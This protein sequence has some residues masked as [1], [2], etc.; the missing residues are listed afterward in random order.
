M[1]ERPLT[2]RGGA[3]FPSRDLIIFVT[4]GV[5]FVTLVLQGFTLAPLL[6][7]LGFVAFEAEASEER[8]VRVAMADAALESL[9]RIGR[10]EKIPGKVVAAM[11]SE[12]ERRKRAA[13]RTHLPQRSDGA[14][15]AAYRSLRRRMQAVE[16]AELL[17]LAEAGKIGGDVM[18]HVQRQ[19]DLRDL[20]LTY[21]EEA[22]GGSHEHLE[23][24]DDFTS[25]REEEASESPG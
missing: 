12:Y 25:A 21:D 20:L 3:A 4:F 24:G 7:R 22:G 1:T 9:R 13:E 14:D 10:E 15:A 19:Q 17:R 11:R 18:R 6:R 16:R 5:I 8:L 2:V 23:P